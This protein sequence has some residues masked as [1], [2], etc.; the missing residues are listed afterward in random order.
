MIRP[1]FSM[2]RFF[3]WFVVPLLVLVLIGAGVFWWLR[4]QAE[5][6]PVG[7]ST[8][9]VSTGSIDET[10]VVTGL[11]KPSVTMDLRSDAS[12]LVESIAV[13]EGDR[14][15]PGQELL[16]LDSRVAQT[17]VQEADA[18]LTQARKEQAASELDLDEDTL[19]LRRTTLERTR[20]LFEQGLVARTELETKELDLKVSERQ[21]ERA[22]RNLETGRARIAQLEA[23]VER[24]QAQLQH[25]IIRAPFEAWVIRRQVE[26]GSGVAGV[27]QGSNG[28]TVVFTLGDARKASLQARV[29]AADARKLQ[30]GMAAQLRLDSEPD[31]P[32]PGHVESVAAA[33]DQDQQTRLTTFPVVIAVDGAADAS[34]INVPAQVDIIM[35]THRDVIVVPDKCVRTDA[36]GRAHVFLKTDGQPPRSQAVALGIASKDR[37]E[38]KSGVSV[39]Q[40]LLCR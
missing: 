31:R 36:G 18:S 38:I 11:V 29:T 26:V 27:S 9:V 7:N 3:R 5:A 14:V 22:R 21:F 1:L 6:A 13:K 30:P 2:R 37:I 35:S 17:A 15:I 33:G 19:A 10:M 23:S 32:R 24:A 28:G 40:S 20:S 16:R 12:G 39:G 8:A 25:T 4:P 34:W